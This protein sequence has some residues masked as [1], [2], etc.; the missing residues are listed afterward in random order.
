MQAFDNNI[1]IYI[2]LIDR[3]NSRILSGNL[4]P[5]EKLDSVR[6][7]ANTYQVNPNTVQ[8]ALADLE[9]TGLIV[10][11]R[12][13]GKFV[14]EDENLIKSVRDEHIDSEIKEILQRLYSEGYTKEEIYNSIK[15]LLEV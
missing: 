3:I 5:G 15:K 6:A 1:P 12:A 13:V 10:S 14:T 8:R 11:K 2:Q 7:L 9:G 4:R